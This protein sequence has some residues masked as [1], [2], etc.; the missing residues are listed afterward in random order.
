[1]ISKET[2]S[3]CISY[4]KSPAMIEKIRRSENLNHLWEIAQDL[5]NN[6]I[7][8]NSKLAN[9]SSDICDLKKRRNRKKLE[10]VKETIINSIKRIK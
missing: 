6:K 9:I 3:L 1:M 4:L 7:L 5:N 8:S 10:R 2:Y